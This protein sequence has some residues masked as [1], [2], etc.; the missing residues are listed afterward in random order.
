MCQRGREGRAARGRVV[1]GS[2][3]ATGPTAIVSNNQQAANRERRIW[4]RKGERQ[5]K[6]KIEKRQG[7]ERGNGK[8]ETGKGMGKRSGEKEWEK[9]RKRNESREWERNGR[10]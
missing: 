10:M 4:L 3:D 5:I 9:M 8:R 7:K 1:G 2:V 6:I